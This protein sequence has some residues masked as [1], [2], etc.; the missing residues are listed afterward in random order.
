MI[1][2]FNEKIFLFLWFWFF[3]V[4]IVSIIQKI[5]LKKLIFIDHFLFNVPLDTHVFYAWP[6]NKEYK[7]RIENLKF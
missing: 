6:G 1:N 2:M 5:I 7:K 4:S 3:M